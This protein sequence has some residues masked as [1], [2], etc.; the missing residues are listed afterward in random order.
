VDHRQSVK[1]KS[2]TIKTLWPACTA[3]YSKASWIGAYSVG[4]TNL[5]KLGCPLKKKKMGVIAISL[6]TIIY[7]WKL[8]K[9][10]VF[11]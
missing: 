7:K 10:W 9:D 11:A 2:T 4:L 6:Q 5:G 1:Y 8:W 3:T